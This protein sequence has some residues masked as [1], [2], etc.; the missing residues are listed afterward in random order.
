MES[1]GESRGGTP[2]PGVRICRVRLNNDRCVSPFDPGGEDLSRITTNVLGIPFGA[3]SEQYSFLTT[4]RHR[5]YVSRASSSCREYLVATDRYR[6]SSP[7][8]RC[9]SYQ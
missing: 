7:S 2:S 5:S 9:F 1:A 3:T 6:T 8:F 4:D